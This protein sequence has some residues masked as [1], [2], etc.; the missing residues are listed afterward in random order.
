MEA[1][2]T[3][4]NP[5]PSE[6]PAA[7]LTEA[8]SLLQ[9]IRLSLDARYAAESEE[10]EA[11]ADEE[12]AL[13]WLG[14]SVAL[15]AF[16]PTFLSIV[17]GV[18]LLLATVFAPASEGPTLAQ[19][20]G[21]QLPAAPATT[22]SW[23]DDRPLGDAWEQGDGVAARPGVGPTKPVKLAATD[24]VTWTRAAALADERAAARLAG[25]LRSQGY[26]VDVRPEDDSTLPWVLWT[27]RAPGRR[28]AK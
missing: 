3:V 20:A 26:R 8:A 25:S 17:L 23:S 10:D 6:S 7:C 13:P 12:H 11:Q 18:P 24:V 27:T 21:P 1:P 4:S 16:V 15:A 14:M 9:D 5:S 19:V 28:A 22:L 2:A